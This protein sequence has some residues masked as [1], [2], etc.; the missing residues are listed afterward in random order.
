MAQIGPALVMWR[1]LR[2]LTTPSDDVPRTRIPAR[3]V[4][5]FLFVWPI[6][7]LCLIR[8]SILGPLTVAASSRLPDFRAGRIQVGPHLPGK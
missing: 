6:A 7:V 1:P 5:D 3:L 2:S 8:S 4:G